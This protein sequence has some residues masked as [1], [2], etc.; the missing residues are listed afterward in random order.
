[1]LFVR[2]SKERV[3]SHVD[4][5]RQLEYGEHYDFSEVLSRHPEIIQSNNYRF[6][7]EN[8]LK[9]FDKDHICIIRHHS[10]QNDG[11][12]AVKR[13]FS[14]LGIEHDNLNR[15]RKEKIGKTITPRFRFLE[16][17]RI[18]IYKTLT[19]NGHQKI[20]NLVKLLKIPEFY[21]T[22]NDNRRKKSDLS[23]AELDKIIGDDYHGFIDWI[24]EKKITVI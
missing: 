3:K 23:Q 12:D 8:Y 7:V 10:I 11:V 21:R 4:W 9:Y 13:F 20:I 6:I 22:F 14:F 16:K 17:M 1:M 18:T 2:D 24:S 19:R 5:L 15:I